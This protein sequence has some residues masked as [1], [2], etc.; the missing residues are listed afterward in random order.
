MWGIIGGLAFVVGLLFA[1]DAVR[2]W[3]RGDYM[4]VPVVLRYR[5]RS[6]L[7]KDA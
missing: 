1:G 4:D 5:F 6:P 3:K 7:P 2:S